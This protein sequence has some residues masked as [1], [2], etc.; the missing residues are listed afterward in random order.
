MILTLRGCSGSGKSYVAHQLLE[1]YPNTPIY[2]GG[3]NQ[4]PNRPKLVGYD[5]PGG[6]L[7]LGRYTA[8]G[9]GLDGFLL[10]KTREKFYALVR[11]A[12]LA[13]PFV[14]GEALTISSSRIWWQ[15]LSREFPGQVIF[16]FLDTPVDLA[17]QRV[18]QRN[19]GR[20]IKEPQLKQHYRFVN[21][22]G[23]RLEA[24]GER[25]Y[26]IDHTRPVEQVIQIFKDEGWQP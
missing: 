10:T 19:G 11:D 23:H 21:R 20:P 22:L 18:L 8:P 15:E 17:I 9:G 6:M 13:A 3:W 24:D 16:A 7:M 1:R 5:L 4:D 26:W 2:L 14:F 25:V 12:F